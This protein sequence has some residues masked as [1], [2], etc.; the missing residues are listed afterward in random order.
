MDKKVS[1]LSK[2][3]S[4]LMNVLDPKTGSKTKSSKKT[5]GTDEGESK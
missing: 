5:V 4:W 1:Q 3:N 2:A